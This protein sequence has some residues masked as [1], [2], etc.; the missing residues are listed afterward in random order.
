MCIVVVYS[1]T[2]VNL[3]I[4]GLYSVFGGEDSK[5]MGYLL[6]KMLNT[7]SMDTKTPNIQDFP[8]KLHSLSVLSAEY[9][10]NSGHLVRFF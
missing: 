4:L 1:E 3:I 5:K 6:S 10:D 2:S 9:S 7:L 8:Q